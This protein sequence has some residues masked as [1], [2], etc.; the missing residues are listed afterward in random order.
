MGAQRSSDPHGAAPD[1]R[2]KR[3]LGN[4]SIRTKIIALVALASVVSGG[5]TALALV[6][7]SHLTEAA[8]Q[9]VLTQKTLSADLTHLTDTVW[10]ARLATTQMGTVFDESKRPAQ[11]AKTDEALDN[12]SLA[13]VA[14]ADMFKDQTGQV[15]PSWQD[16]EAGWSNYLEVQRGKMMPAALAGDFATFDELRATDRKSVV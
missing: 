6:S 3:H 15:P 16:F 4:W 1:P 5:L 11:F 8:D 13:T 10:Q 2:S 14:F 7:M 9:V 12:V